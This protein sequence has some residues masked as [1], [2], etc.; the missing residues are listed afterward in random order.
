[1]PFYEVHLHKTEDL[2]GRMVIKADTQQ[3]ARSMALEAVEKDHDDVID[4]SIWE[5]EW[6][7]L[8]EISAPDEPDFNFGAAYWDT[9]LNKWTTT[10][11]YMF[12]NEEGKPVGNPKK[13]G[14]SV[15]WAPYEEVGDWAL[16]SGPSHRAEDK[17]WTPPKIPYKINDDVDAYDLQECPWCGD[18]MEHDGDHSGWYADCSNCG[19]VIELRT[20]T[21]NVIVDIEPPTEKWTTDLADFSAES[22]NSGPGILTKEEYDAL[23]GQF[24]SM[25][26]NELYMVRH[27]LN[28]RLIQLGMNPD[29]Y[30]AESSDPAE[31]P[32]QMVE[33]F[34]GL[35]RKTMK[36]MIGMIDKLTDP[37]VLSKDNVKDLIDQ[38]FELG[39][40][41]GNID[42][43][44]E[45]RQE[46][47]KSWNAEDWKLETPIVDRAMRL[48][49][50]I[51][52]ATH[53]AMMVAMEQ[54]A[55]LAML[56]NEGHWVEHRAD[57]K[58]LDWIPEDFGLVEPAELI[59]EIEDMEEHL[60]DLENQ[61]DY[62]L[63]E[64]NEDLEYIL[65]EKI[66]EVKEDIEY[67]IHLLYEVEAHQFYYEKDEDLI[68]MNDGG[69]YDE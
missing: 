57:E 40:N 59:G 11:P 12:A 48:H 37:V 64:D 20:I 47:L 19:G 1:M 39:Y 63:E 3:E 32:A 68:Y 10:K 16:P 9:N 33:Q 52:R 60:G 4:Y 50:M 62:A 8:G 44:W 46:M 22:F 55:L 2:V 66:I 29:K 14:R 56:T 24:D 65:E 23:M 5:D 53:H 43:K 7:Q 34:Q 15:D 6:I 25:T 41:S 26:I 67:L 69:E 61:Y 28:M 17:E 58:D 27:Q 54:Q 30:S 42:G 45:M 18:D 49:I 35:V 13:L 38:S 21:E 51:E 36:E 31:T